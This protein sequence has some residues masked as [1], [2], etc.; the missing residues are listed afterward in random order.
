MAKCAAIW[1]KANCLSGAFDTIEV[2]AQMRCVVLSVTRC[3]SEYHAIEK[4]MSLP[5]GQLNEIC[6]QLKV[7]NLHPE[8]SF[9]LK[10]YTAIL[11]PLAPPAL[12]GK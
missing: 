2:I 6:D 3:S 8:E 12:R 9:F 10:E 4:L 7:A 11:K 1:N 5:E